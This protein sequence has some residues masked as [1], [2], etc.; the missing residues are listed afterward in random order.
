MELIT[1]KRLHLFSG[2]SHLPLAEEIAD[3][4]GIELSDPNLAE[5][6]NG[7]IHCRFGDSV[8]GGRRLHRAE[9]H[10]SWEDHSINDAIMEHLIMVDAAEPGVGQADH[11]RCARF[12]G[13]ARQDRKSHGPRTHLRQACVAD[14]FRLPPAPDRHH[15]GGPALRVRSR[16]SSTSPWSTT[17]RPC[18]S[19]C[20]HDARRLGDDLVVVSPDAGR[21]KVAERYAIEIGADLAIVHK[22][23]ISGVE[24]RGGGQGGRR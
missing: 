14:A 16:V 13:Y 20:E 12:Y 17:S 8:R 11:R 6:A 22:R 21:V 5:F 19:W 3:H 9:P 7:E 2:R 4:L 1:K 10:V 23:R 24:E 18:P 15:L